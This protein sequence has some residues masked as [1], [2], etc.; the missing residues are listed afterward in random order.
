MFLNSL[1][2]ISLNVLMFFLIS[3]LTFTVLV[4]GGVLCCTS[5]TQPN[6][7]E[8]IVSLNQSDHYSGY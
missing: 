1:F 8:T 2:H 7:F 4:L 5:V 3:A 6:E